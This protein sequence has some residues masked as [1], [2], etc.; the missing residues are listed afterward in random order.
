MF[1]EIEMIKADAELLAAEEDR[2]YLQ[3]ADQSGNV[4]KLPMEEKKSL[5]IAMA[6]HE[7]G[8]AAL[9]QNQISLAL[10]FFYE[11]DSSFS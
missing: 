8:R 10:T 11:A 3:I 7:K 1:R 2:N 9:K 6:L 4:L 5:A